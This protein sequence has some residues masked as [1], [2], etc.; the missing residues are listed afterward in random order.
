MSNI[1][2]IR[3]KLECPLDINIIREIVK[4]SGFT[5]YFGDYYKQHNYLVM[6]TDPG[7]Y[8]IICVIKTGFITI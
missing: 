6:Q 5:L 3:V 8:D 1:W 7:F 2:A 4:G